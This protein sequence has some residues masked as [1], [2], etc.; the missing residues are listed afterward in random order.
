MCKKLK[1]ITT[2]LLVLLL[3]SSLEAKEF[4]FSNKKFKLDETSFTRTVKPRLYRILDG[5]F[6]IIKSFA[7]ENGPVVELGKNSFDLLESFHKISNI[8]LPND[9]TLA[10]ILKMRSV[11]NTNELLILQ[12]KNRKVETFPQQNADILFF[13]EPL[14]QNILKNFLLLSELIESLNILYSFSPESLN[15]KV[16][17]QIKEHLH[18]Y[19][20]NVDI[21]VSYFV[22]SNK[23]ED[24]EVL[25][26]SFF[27]PIRDN[28]LI[29]NDYEFFGNRFEAFNFDWNDFHHKS[30]TDKSIN[31]EVLNRVQ[32]EWNQILRE[33]F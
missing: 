25:W 28:I 6:D 32:S 5:Y 11:L 24:V 19:V 22:N 26:S 14:L 3:S 31:G 8:D 18:F 12:L 27:K 33:V 20:V 13:Q 2:L 10:E 30:L 15:T 21:L 7:P 23:Q 29:N 9:E 16:M 4:S 17:G 1:R